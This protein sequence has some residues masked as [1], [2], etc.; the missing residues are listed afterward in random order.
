[1]PA[2]H[3]LLRVRLFL[4][5]HHLPV[6]TLFVDVYLAGCFHGGGRVVDIS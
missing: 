5:Q 3:I 4:L 2:Y 1:M 6:T